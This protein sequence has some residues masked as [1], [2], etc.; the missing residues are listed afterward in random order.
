MENIH[1]RSMMNKLY[2]NITNYRAAE[3]WNF[4]VNE[5]RAFRINTHLN[6]RG[7]AQMLY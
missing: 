6:W 1:E 4:Q 2:G 7:I 5:N 3:S